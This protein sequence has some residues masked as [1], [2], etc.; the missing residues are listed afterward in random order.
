VS[1]GVMPRGSLDPMWS[2]SFSVG[3]PV[4]AGRKQ[5]RAVAE[6][7]A[8]RDAEG[9]GAEA[10]QQILRLRTEER[11]ALLESTLRANQLYRGGL[12]VQSEAATESTMS[13]Y[14]V[15]RVTFASVLEVLNGYV[16]DRASF[17]ESMA[18]AQRIAISQWEL[19][20]EAPPGS[21]A[22]MGAGPVPGA[23]AV[24]GGQAKAGMG[25]GAGGEPAAPSARGG[26]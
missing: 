4:W 17:L 10:I 25:G 21:A 14:K 7:E 3:L 20:L 26:M 22:S 5:A 18:Q 11:L 6:G 23:G 16:A 8:R 2:L 19:S 13:Q 24:G 1:A 12:L 9:Q 15:G